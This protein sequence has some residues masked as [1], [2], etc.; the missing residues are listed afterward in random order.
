MPAPAPGATGELSRIV[1]ESDCVH[2]GAY[3][4]LS[5]PSLV[6]LLEEAA[7]EALR[8][9]LAPGQDSVGSRVEVRHLAPTPRGMRVTAVATVTEVDRRRVTFSVAIDDERERIG[10]AAHDRFIIDLAKFEE[11]LAAKAGS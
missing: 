8:P 7:I 6:R 2:R 4:V 1:E 9:Y 3:A 5:T 10:E 11:R